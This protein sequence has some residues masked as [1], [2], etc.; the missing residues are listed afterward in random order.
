M[1]KDEII[2]FFEKVM[3]FNRL[4]RETLGEMADDISMEYYPRESRFCSRTARPANFSGSSK[5]GV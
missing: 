5:R 2:D 1:L 3:P 4:S